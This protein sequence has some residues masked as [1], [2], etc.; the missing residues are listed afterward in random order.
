MT[1]ITLMTISPVKAAP[2]VKVQ[3]LQVNHMYPI[4]D[5]NYA[6][7]SISKKLNHELPAKFSNNFSTGLILTSSKLLTEE[8]SQV[9]MTIVTKSN[10]FFTSAMMVSEKLNQ[11]IAYF[12]SSNNDGIA[13]KIE[14]TLE[15][16]VIKKKCSS[17]V[18]YS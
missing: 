9:A 12:T 1:F 11:L 7:L 6:P 13:E 4:A 15:N 2:S 17:T 5:K 3:Y 10:H 14:P 16:K 18:S 8:N